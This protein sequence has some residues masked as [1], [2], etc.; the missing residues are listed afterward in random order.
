M[1]FCAEPVSGSMKKE[2]PIARF[3]DDTSGSFVDLTGLHPWPG[4]CQC[5]LDRIID[6]GVNVPISLWT[7][8]EQNHPRDV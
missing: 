8:A 3:R 4:G 7:I 5:R 6:D 1:H 2:L